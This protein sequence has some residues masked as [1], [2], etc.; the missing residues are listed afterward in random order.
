[1]FLRII[2]IQREKL[3]QFLAFYIEEDWIHACEKCIELLLSERYGHTL[4]I[5]SKDE[6][7]V[8]NQFALRN[9]W[10]NPVN[11]PGTF[12]SMGATTKLIS[13]Q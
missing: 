4:I 11:T 9:C 3:A 7:E 5:H 13:F 8:I 2:I 10:K 12:G 1:M 6:D